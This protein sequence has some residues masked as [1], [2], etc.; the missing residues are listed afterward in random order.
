MCGRSELGDWLGCLL[1][2]QTKDQMDL[3]ITWKNLPQR[4]LHTEDWIGA[5]DEAVLSE[6]HAPVST[7]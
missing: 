7:L 1:Q 3:L 6:F 2:A 4:E 5:F